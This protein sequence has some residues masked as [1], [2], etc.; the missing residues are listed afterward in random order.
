MAVCSVWHY[1]TREMVDVYMTSPTGES[2]I[3]TPIPEFCNARQNTQRMPSRFYITPFILCSESLKRA[4]SAALPIIAH[5]P[6]LG[7]GS[8]SLCQACL[9]W[10]LAGQRTAPCRELM[11]PD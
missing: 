9:E 3:H 10:G 4:A 1:K 8:S 11:F 6:C 7:A 2:C 5:Q